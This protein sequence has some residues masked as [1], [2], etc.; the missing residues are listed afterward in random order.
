MR[1]E[2]L[3]AVIIRDGYNG[4]TQP[5]HLCQAT[6]GRIWGVHKSGYIIFAD[7]ANSIPP[8]QFAVGPGA[9]NCP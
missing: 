8:L 7:P 6:D 9:V 3:R 5:L 1:T 2:Y 4:H